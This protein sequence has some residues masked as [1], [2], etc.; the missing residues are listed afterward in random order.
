LETTPICAFGA[1]PI[2]EEFYEAKLIAPS[3]NRTGQNARLTGKDQAAAVITKEWD[4]KKFTQLMP[5]LSP[6]EHIDMNL[7]EM[8]EARE[9]A[10]DAKLAECEAERDKADRE[11]QT[12]QAGLQDER[13]KADVRM[14]TIHFIIILVAATLSPFLAVLL[15]RIIPAANSR[16]A[17]F[18]QPTAPV[19]ALIAKPTAAPIPNA[20]NPPVH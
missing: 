11:W 10:R 12:K 4:C 6:K 20:T 15:P 5:G 14:R 16:Q 7:V 8:R 1:Y 9:D 17:V 18:Q 13:H 2:H 3:V 19:S